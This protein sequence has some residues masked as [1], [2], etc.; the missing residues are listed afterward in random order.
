MKKLYVFCADKTDEPYSE[1]A[2]ADSVPVDSG[3]RTLFAV[4]ESPML[5]DVVDDVL[6]IIRWGRNAEDGTPV[7]GCSRSA[8]VLCSDICDA[9][10]GLV[11][12]PF[13]CHKLIDTE[14]ANGVDCPTRHGMKSATLVYTPSTEALSAT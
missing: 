13:V 12:V 8:R 5:E 4:F 11:K 14:F 1:I 10:I 6:R 7:E 2:I 3:H 9:M